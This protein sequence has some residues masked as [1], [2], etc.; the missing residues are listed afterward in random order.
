MLN[1]EAKIQTENMKPKKTKA[2]KKKKAKPNKST[3]KPE[4]LKDIQKSRTISAGNS[5]SGTITK[6]KMPESNSHTQGTVFNRSIT[7]SNRSIARVTNTSLIDP[8]NEKLENSNKDTTTS[9]SGMQ[10]SMRKSIL[11][12]RKNNVLNPLKKFTLNVQ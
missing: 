9:S 6:N 1:D 7:L 3:L 11:M 5:N 8:N 4:N 12:S 2:K 10:E